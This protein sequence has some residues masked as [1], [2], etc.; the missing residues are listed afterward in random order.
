MKLVSGELIHETGELIL[1][2][3]ELILETVTGRSWSSM[4]D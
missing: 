3:G 2:T 4:L 1:E